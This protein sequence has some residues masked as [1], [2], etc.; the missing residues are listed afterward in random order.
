MNQF[1]SLRIY[2]E[3]NSIVAAWSREY[4]TFLLKKANL[5]RDS[6]AYAD[7]FICGFN[8]SNANKVTLEIWRRYRHVLPVK[9]DVKTANIKR[10]INAVRRHIAQAKKARTNINKTVKAMSTES[11]LPVN[12]IN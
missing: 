1:S 6:K 3:A 5:G 12:G 8:L 4:A 11:R 7:Q 10:M 9:G 2:N